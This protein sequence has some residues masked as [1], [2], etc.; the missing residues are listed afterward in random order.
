MDLD[1]SQPSS[2]KQK[3]QRDAE[4]FGCYGLVGGGA[5]V[6]RTEQMVYAYDVCR[7]DGPFYCAV[8]YSDAIV[9]KCTE[10]KD[11]FAHIAPLSPALSEGESERHLECK[12]EICAALQVR[13]PEGKWEVERTIPANSEKKIREVRPDI[14]GRIQ[15]GRVAI[16]VQASALSITGILKRTLTYS[17]RGIPILWV[18][19]L[20]GPL[21]DEVFRPRLYERY[22]H[23]IYF[24]RTYYWWPG[25]G[26]SV[27]PVHYGSA[28]RHI[29]YSEWYEEGGEHCEAGGYD[30]DYKA[31]KSPMFGPP[32]DISSNFA[33]STRGAFTPDNER[34][35]VP[36]CR[37]WFD[38][39]DPWW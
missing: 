19:P 23:S 20:R 2:E 12:R 13:H 39:M 3:R 37:L 5:K 16:E 24:G 38:H 6:L 4:E 32:L 34:K 9:K 21:T 30:K 28:T 25:L 10:K 1:D 35:A 22:F 29:P 31:I 17:K 8:C 15:Q 26:A 18:V 14:S 11:H 27:V 7:E 33:A 36:A